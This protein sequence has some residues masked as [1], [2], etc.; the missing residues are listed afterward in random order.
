MK[1]ERRQFTVE[2]QGPFPI[3]MLRYDQCW[4]K[5]EGEDTGVIEQ[6]IRSRPPRQAPQG[7]WPPY[8]VTLETDSESA[9]TYGRWESFG[10]KVAV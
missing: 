3:D 1:K 8:R 7:G 6:S 4:P 2:G 5:S 9:P 10:W